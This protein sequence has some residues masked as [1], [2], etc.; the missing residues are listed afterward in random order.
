MSSLLVYPLSAIFALILFT[1]SSHF[2]SVLPHS[3]FFSFLLSSWLLILSLSPLLA[4]HISSPLSGLCLLSQSFRFLNRELCQSPGS[5]PCQ[6]LLSAH[7]FICLCPPSHLSPSP[8]LRLWC[9]SNCPPWPACRHSHTFTCAH[10]CMHTQALIA[11]WRSVKLQPHQHCCEGIA[12][13]SACCLLS[14]PPLALLLLPP[15]F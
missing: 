8:C 10:K 14:S 2:L 1:N 9:V 5:C 4:F 12:V 3:I 13:C 6:S 7:L 11:T 15:L